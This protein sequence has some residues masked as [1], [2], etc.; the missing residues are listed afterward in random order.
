MFQMP[1]F[2]INCDTECELGVHPIGDSVGGAQR[3]KWRQSGKAIYNIGNAIYDMDP[4]FTEKEI[5]RR[6]Y[7][8]IENNSQQEPVF[9]PETFL[10]IVSKNGIT[11]IE[12]NISLFKRNLFIN[13]HDEKVRRDELR[14]FKGSV[15]E[16]S[17]YEELKDVLKGKEAFI[18]HGCILNLKESS[19]S[20]KKEIDFVILHKRLRQIVIFEIKYSFYRGKNFCPC[21]RSILQ[22][23]K[24][25]HF[26]E[27]L[28]DELQLQNWS[29]VLAI[30]FMEHSY[31]QEQRVKCCDYCKPF[32][33]QSGELK[34]LFNGLED[35]LQENTDNEGYKKNN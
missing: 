13:F 27:Q 14:R 15:A 29:F 3:N 6:N 17:F 9:V 22:L 21:K 2:S 1:A 11:P 35:H 28:I 10:P 34:Y 5:L 33:V 30:G 19:F 20:Q 8:R 18:L 12:S 4:E 16:M 32:L 24:T 7:P 26:L 23:R 25:K 31:N